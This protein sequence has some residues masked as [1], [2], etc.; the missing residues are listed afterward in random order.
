[1]ND[2]SGGFLMV[3]R[4]GLFLEKQFTQKGAI[5]PR[6]DWAFHQTCMLIAPWPRLHPRTPGCVF[7][8]KPQLQL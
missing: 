8:L 6:K 5:L 2:K 7:S 1:M 3:A 4:E